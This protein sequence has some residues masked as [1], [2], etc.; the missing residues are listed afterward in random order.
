MTAEDIN[1][2]FS[3]AK[4]VARKVAGLDT[5][6][7]IFLDEINTASVLGLIKEIIVD[8]SLNGEPLE[9]NN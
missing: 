3:E 9:E 5:K 6:V 1:E 2:K 8:R 4:R 7:V